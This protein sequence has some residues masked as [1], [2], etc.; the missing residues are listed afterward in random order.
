MRL[1]RNSHE[2]QEVLGRKA[3]AEIAQNAI[4]FIDTHPATIRTAIYFNFGLIA[5]DPDD[6]KF[7]DCAI[8]A[9]ADYLV[10]N[11]SHFRTLRE[12]QFPSVAVMSVDE[13]ASSFQQEFSE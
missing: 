3:N 4:N 5:D 8:S 9:N 10:S 13:F 12:I 2:Y 11:D 1:E 7:V 6:N